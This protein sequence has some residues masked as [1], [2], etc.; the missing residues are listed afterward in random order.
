MESSTTVYSSILLLG[1]AHGVFLAIALLNVN[2][3]NRVAL[4]LLGLLTISFAIDLGINYL[5]VSGN[6]VAQPRLAFVESLAVF[7]YGPFL[8]LY[9]AALSSRTPWRPKKPDWLHFVPFL[10]GVGLVAPFLT[11]DDET[12]VDII[13]NGASADRHG[14]YLTAAKFY[15][16]ALPRLL[17]A[18]YLVLGFRR[19]AL[20]GRTIRDSFSDIESISLVWLR[21]LLIAISGLWALYLVALAFG[22]R[23]LVESVLNVAIVVVVYTLGYMGLRQPVIFTQVDS[24]T[25][26]N[27]PASHAEGDA[28]RSSTKGRYEKSALD[29]QAS[30]AL[31][32]ELTSL[33]ADQHPYLDNSL[34]LAQLAEHM[35]LS[36]NYLSQVINQQAGKNFFDYINGFRVEAAKSLLADPA[37]QRVNILTIAMDSGFNSKSAFYTAFKHHTSQTPNQFRR[38]KVS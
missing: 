23:G 7:L 8:L 28:A 15:L 27:K 14:F 11:L 38:E 34:T 3:G 32:T 30:S 16:D 29:E 13:Y 21:N 12:L 36:P 17:I 18:T 4:R 35:K 5:L 33:M 26:G 10:L 31:F 20:H 9:V 37:K 25:A 2:S 24:V 19:L 6:I 1:S 22:G